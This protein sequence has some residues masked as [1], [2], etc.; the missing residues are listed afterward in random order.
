MLKAARDLPQDIPWI[1]N[2]SAFILLY[3]NKFPYDLTTIYPQIAGAKNLPFGNGSSEL[4]R[5]F[6]EEN[7]AL[8][9]HQPQ[10]ENDLRKLVVDSAADRVEIFTAGLEIY[11]QSYDGEIYFYK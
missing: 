1:S 5:I 3:L 6:R 8:L 7:A 10:F 9:L 2:Q 4:D 11:Q